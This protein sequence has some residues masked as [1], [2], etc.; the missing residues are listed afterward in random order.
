MSRKNKTIIWSLLFILLAGLMFAITTYAYFS[1]REVYDGTFQIDVTSKGVDTLKFEK[2]DAKFVADVSNFAIHVGH[3]VSGEAKLD[4]IL[5]TTNKETK[6]CYETTIKLPEEEVFVYTV[7][8][9]P[10]LVLDISK[11]SDGIHYNNIVTGMD[12]TTKTG[13]IKIPISED[14]EDYKNVISTT[15]GVVTRDYWKAKLTFKWLKDAY[16]EE[17]DYKSYKAVFEANIV[18]CQLFLW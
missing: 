6:Y 13:S 1:T 17:N 5:D 11:S 10:E 7:E 15:K 18:E 3:D 14:S 16:Q 2:S 12:I 4:V 9:V 8:G